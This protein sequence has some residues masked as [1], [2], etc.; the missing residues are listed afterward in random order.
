MCVYRRLELFLKLVP[1]RRNFLKGVFRDLEVLAWG[2]FALL[3]WVNAI[4]QHASGCRAFVPCVRKIYL[5]I[6][7]KGDGSFLAIGLAISE[8]PELAARW[9]YLKVKPMAVKQLNELRSSLHALDLSILSGL[10]TAAYN[11]LQAVPEYSRRGQESASRSLRV[12]VAG[13]RFTAL[14]HTR[15][16]LGLNRKRHE[17]GKQKKPRTQ[18]EIRG[19]VVFARS[20]QTSFW[21]R[22]WDSNPRYDLT[23]A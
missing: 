12:Y 14:T 5:R 20:L 1:L 4:Q 3:E 13:I 22:G 19:T 21:R 15:E 18:Y 17:T 16:K 11:L 8:P 23:Y 2:V 6:R 7:T 10:L 9:L